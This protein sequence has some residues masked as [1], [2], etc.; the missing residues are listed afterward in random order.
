MKTIETNRGVQAYD[1]LVRD[2]KD[3]VRPGDTVKVD[4]APG[5]RGWD[6]K[7]ILIERGP[8]G[9]PIVWVTAGHNRAGLRYVGAARVTRRR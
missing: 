3:T 6:G 8:G 5:D 1:E 2:G 7:V 4:S 9:K